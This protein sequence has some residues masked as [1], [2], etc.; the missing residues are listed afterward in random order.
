MDIQYDSTVT[1]DRCTFS[2][3]TASRDGGAITILYG[4]DVTIINNTANLGSV[5]LLKCSAIF[6]NTTL[7]KKLWIIAV[8]QN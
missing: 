1:F 6:D 5:Y 4:N 2:G 7:S 8:I 3:N